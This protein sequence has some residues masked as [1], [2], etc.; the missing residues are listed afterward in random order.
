MVTQTE[1]KCKRFVEKY[2]SD[3][4]GVIS[5]GRLLI[6]V[7]RKSR[8]NFIESGINRVMIH[9]GNKNRKPL[10]WNKCQSFLDIPR[11][12]RYYKY[13]ESLCIGNQGIRD[14]SIARRRDRA[15]NSIF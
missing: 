7:N 6:D 2:V 13:I 10:I 5:W 8:Y 9:M 1:E 3:F 14:Q 11:L 4:V 12:W 15:E